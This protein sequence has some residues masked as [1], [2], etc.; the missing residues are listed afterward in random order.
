MVHTIAGMG[1]ALAAASF[2]AAPLHDHP[3]NRSE[4]FRP[5]REDY[6]RMSQPPQQHNP[7]GTKLGKRLKA[8]KKLWRA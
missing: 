6:S 3:P 1:M 7:A 5:R 4:S 8:G 2:I